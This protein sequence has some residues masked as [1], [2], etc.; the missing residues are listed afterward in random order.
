VEFILENLLDALSDTWTM[1]PLLYIAYLVIEHFERKPSEDDNIYFWLQKYGPLFGAC[2]GLLPQCGFSILA[3]ML[4]VQNYISLGTLAAV[5]IATSDEAIPVLI[6]EPEMLPSLVVLLVIKFVLALAVGFLVDKV[7]FPK[8][9]IIW[10]DTLD[11]EEEYDEEEEMSEEASSSCPCCYPQ[12]PM[13][14]SAAIRTLRIYAFVFV[15]TFIL[16]LI[17]SSVGTEQLSAV[18]LKGSF[19]QPILAALIGFIPNCAATVVLCQLF[20]A[21]QLSFASLLSGLI[22]NAGLGLVCLFQYGASKKNIIRIICI[23]FITALVAGE[24]ILFVF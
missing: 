7:I 22:T 2:L 23:L 17:L 14:L 19:L 11:E 13:W 6:S 8:Q 12:Y 16:N 10:F 18:L 20:A 21:G 15:T 3:S 1:L 24:F 4:F 5:F 9:K